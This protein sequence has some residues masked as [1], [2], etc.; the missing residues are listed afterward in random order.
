LLEGGI[1]VQLVH[2]S[3]RDESNSVRTL[4]EPAAPASK[5]PDTPRSRGAVVGV[6]T[7]LFALGVAEV[8][9][10]FID[11]QSSPLVAVGSA[12]IDATPE[13]LK[14][15]AIRTFGVNDKRALI[16]GMIV[17]I[18]I[19]AA[20]L[21][22]ASIRRPWIGL[23]GLWVLAAVGAVAAFKRPTGSILSVVPSIVGA[24]AGS[25][26]LTWLLG[27]ARP[28]VVRDNGA[29]GTPL[30]TPGE[31]DRR[32]FLFASLTIGAAAVVA[33]GLGRFIS[34]RRF[35]VAE[36]A[37]DA[38]TIPAPADPAPA[39]PA[40]FDTPGLSSFITP[41]TDFY[42]VDTALVVPRV[43][44]DGWRLTIHGM[45]DHEME[46]TL[47]DLMAR[48]LIERDITLTC[49]SNEIGGP[50][51]GNARWVG[52]PLKPLLD[53]A[54]VHPGAD[55]IVTR[56]VDGFT[57]GT[58][59]AVATDGRDA[60][61]AISM[62][63]EVLPFA[64]GFPVRMI[65]PGL[66]GYVSATKWLTDIEL[67]TFDAYDAYWVQRGWAQQAAIKTESRIDTPRSNAKVGTVMVAGVAW[68]QHR[69]IERVE[70]RVDDGEWNDTSLSTQDTTDTWR[71]W[72]WPWQA[73]AGS[74]TLQARATD[75]DGA[76]QPEQQLP[77]FPNGA[78]GWHTVS[79]TVG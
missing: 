48:D 53:E 76:T 38:L 22:I 32:R 24:F 49:V 3:H 72:R 73:T 62:N 64:H 36:A 29:A 25:Y 61:L 57:V 46:L 63:G 67:T 4:N 5:R 77:P 39:P 74:H 68:A 50:Y 55:Q 40:G 7:A 27:A 9:A 31:V 17:V 69:G 79:V 43:D 19:L 51:I 60:M 16:V 10:S 37:R 21:G 28:S 23:T 11:D 12:M 65:V 41:N 75:A 6:L 71:Q 78:T 44:T 8:V 52:A 47:D 26:A 13:W 54:G 35:G 20:V 56:S 18:L 58:P 70:V 30:E 42:R 66:Y 14:S 15:F 34:S 1:P 33:G 59:T 2:V 45:V